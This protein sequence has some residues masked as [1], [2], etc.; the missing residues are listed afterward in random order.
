MPCP[1]KWETAGKMPAL[2][3]DRTDAGLPDKSRRAPTNRG[4]ARRYKGG[5]KADP[6]LRQASLAAV[7]ATVLS[8]PLTA[9]N[10]GPG[11]G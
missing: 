2:R 1:Y 7:P 4:K 3:H 9:G 5:Q 6:C 8:R 11:S 10:A